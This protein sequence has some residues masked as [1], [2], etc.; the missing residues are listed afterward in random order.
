[1]GLLMS[2]IQFLWSLDLVVVSVS[3]MGNVVCCW[4]SQSGGKLF[5]GLRCCDT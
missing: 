1:M 5:Q 2:G 4:S 3:G